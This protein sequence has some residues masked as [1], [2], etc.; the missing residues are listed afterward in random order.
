M[1][2]TYNWASTLIH[3]GA[4][5]YI[6]GFLVRDELLLRLLV[7]GGSGLYILYYFLFPATPLWDA[8]ITSLI[9]GVANI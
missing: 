2:E 1:P 3:L 4:L 8:I 6:L 7:L 5:L 9:L